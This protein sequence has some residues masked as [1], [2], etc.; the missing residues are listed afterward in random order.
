MRQSW[1][2]M[3]V[4]YP[5]F[6]SRA[7]RLTAVWFQIRS[8]RTAACDTGAELDCRHKSFRW[9]KKQYDNFQHVQ[10]TTIDISVDVWLSVAEGP[11]TRRKEKKGPTL[12]S[13]APQPTA[14]TCT[15]WNHLIVKNTDAPAGEVRAKSE[16][17][18]IPGSKAER[19]PG[20][21]TCR[22]GPK[23]VS[24]TR[25]TK[26]DDS[27]I[28][29]DAGKCSDRN[30][31]SKEH[32]FCSCATLCLAQPS[33]ALSGGVQGHTDAPKRFIISRQVKGEQSGTGAPS[34]SISR[35]TWKSS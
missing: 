27:K 3:S 28:H 34:A 12:T 20:T 25:A 14:C 32:I 23:S 21:Q 2:I 22:R 19:S 33:Q 16:G 26:P 31:F 11:R 18:I 1:L 29:H 6:I 13:E 30:P 5:V 4:S 8:L 7:H 10:E 24:K 35:S 9:K 17:Q 15:S